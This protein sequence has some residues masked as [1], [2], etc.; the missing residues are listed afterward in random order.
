MGSNLHVEEYVSTKHI[1]LN[2][3]MKLSQI[4]FLGTLKIMSIKNFIFYT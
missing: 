1:Y 3:I 2:S 4:Y